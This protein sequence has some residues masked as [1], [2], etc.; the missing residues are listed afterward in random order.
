MT[1]AA[2]LTKLQ[3]DS[4]SVIL[5]AERGLASPAVSML[6][7]AFEALVLLTLVAEDSTFGPGRVGVGSFDDTGE[8][9]HVV[10]T[11]R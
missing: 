4:Q 10:V 1:A 6:R 9:R 5:N 11:G 2:L 8:F 7:V 3:V